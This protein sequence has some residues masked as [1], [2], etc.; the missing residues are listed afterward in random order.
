MTETTDAAT[1]TALAHV[2]A[3]M[4]DVWRKLI[5]DHVDAG[6]GRCRACTRAGTGTPGKTWP[7]STL[8]LARVAQR[9]HDEHQR[10]R[11]R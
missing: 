8:R 11:P 2:L 5:V 9:I 6:C 3:D 1:W 7:C 4:P 10:G